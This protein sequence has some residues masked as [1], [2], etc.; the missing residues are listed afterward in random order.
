MVIGANLSA[1]IY[2]IGVVDGVVVDGVSA[3]VIV[4]A[5]RARERFLR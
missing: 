3:A 4:H 5:M 1:I 2:E